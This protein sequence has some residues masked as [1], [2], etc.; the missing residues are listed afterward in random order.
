MRRSAGDLARLRAAFGDPG[1]AER[2][3]YFIDEESKRHLISQMRLT[4][5]QRA[6]L[7]PRRTPH[8]LSPNFRTFSVNGSSYQC[9]RFLGTTLLLSVELGFS[10]LSASP[11]RWAAT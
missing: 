9:V 6:A 11:E 10:G 2:A 4:G 5:C 3:T 8:R 1:N 7:S